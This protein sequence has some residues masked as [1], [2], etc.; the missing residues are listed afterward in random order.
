MFAEEV[1]LY[2]YV[3]HHDPVYVVHKYLPSRF[4]SVSGML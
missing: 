2:R 1:W 4:Q 3:M